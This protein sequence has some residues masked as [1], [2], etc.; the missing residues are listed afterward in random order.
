MHKQQ[1]TGQLDNHARGSHRFQSSMLGQG[2][3]H[4]G[5]STLSWREK[6]P[7]SKATV[8]KITCSF[9][10]RSSVRQKTGPAMPPVESPQRS[11]TGSGGEACNKFYS[12]PCRSVATRVLDIEPSG[13]VRGAWPS[14]ALE[15]PCRVLSH[16]AKKP[17]FDY[18]YRHPGVRC[19]GRI[20]FFFEKSAPSFPFS[21][22]LWNT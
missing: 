12:D 13:S 4:Y 11:W 3:S 9:S 20:L 21:S 22:S 16:R 8:M 2:S 5:P 14:D 19:Q 1:L 15:A 17:P 18:T 10:R 6:G 7:G